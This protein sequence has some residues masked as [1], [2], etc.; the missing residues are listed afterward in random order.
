MNGIIDSG[1]AAFD[2]TGRETIRGYRLHGKEWF[3]TYFFY[4]TSGQLVRKL[5]GDGDTAVD[6]FIDKWVYD[7]HGRVVREV[8]LL[9]NES[10]DEP[11]RSREFQYDSL[12]RL[13]QQ[14]ER[15]A[16]DK[17]GAKIKTMHVTYSGNLT[18]KCDLYASGDTFSVD[19]SYRSGGL[20]WSRLYFFDTEAHSNRVDKTL[21][22]TSSS[23]VDTIAMKNK[24]RKTTIISYQSYMYDFRRENDTMYQEMDNRMIQE[25]GLLYVDDYVFTRQG[26]FDYMMRKNRQGQPILR[27][28][29][30]YTYYK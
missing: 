13:V 28:T 30:T 17:T 6:G 3:I 9:R 8:T 25:R 7:A 4:N 16:Y 20:Y 27:R 15:Y 5:S 29:K 23:R 26:K 21:C 19:T 2:S 10:G 18:I 22:S 1:Y 14:V 24:T 11:F 12:N